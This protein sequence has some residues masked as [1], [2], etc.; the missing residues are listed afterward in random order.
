M[1]DCAH[2]DGLP[3]DVVLVHDYLNQYGGAER[4]VLELAAMF[5]GAPLYT[6]LYRRASTFA[7]CADLDIHTTFLDRLPVDR[8]FRALFPLYPIAFHSLGKI[9]ADLVI[10]SSSGWAHGVHTTART[11]HAVYCY[12]PPRWLY[13]TYVGHNSAQLVMRPVAGV[14]RSIDARSARRPDLYITLSQHVRAR[15]RQRYGRDAAVV[16]PPVDTG[17]FTPSPRGERLLVVSRLLPYKRLDLVVDA[18]T[19]AN[20]ELDIVGTGPALAS[21]RRRAGP[22]VHFLGHLREPELIAKYERCRAYLQPGVEDFGMAPLEANAAGKPVVAF[23]GGGA[24]ETVTEGVSG[25]LFRVASPAKL[26]EALRRCDALNSSPEQIAAH[27]QR[28]SIQRFRSRLVA[29]LAEGMTDRRP[30]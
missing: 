3:A 18:A 14:F 28:F 13:G 6:S 25:T 21:L 2:V 19:Q 8:H 9:D 4:V 27:A 10:S 29:A 1:T 20:L 17:R 15:I 12:T 26:L 24:L 11:F 30:R 22:T 7:Q 16:H 5:P 23:A